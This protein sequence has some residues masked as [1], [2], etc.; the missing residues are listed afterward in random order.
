S[1]SAASFPLGS[2]RPYSR[3]RMVTRWPGC[4]PMVDEPSAAAM[5]GPSTVTRTV[6]SRDGACSNV[7]IAVATLV[8]LAGAA[9]A[10]AA[11][12]KSNSP[13]SS[14]TTATSGAVTGG[15]AMASWRCGPGRASGTAL[16]PSSSDEVIQGGGPLG[17]TSVL[18]TQ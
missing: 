16:S 6:V 18:A 1:C 14:S 13:V 12:P 2:S 15:G 17:A 9:C 11:R 8:V 5:A 7:T 10:W 4:K 3:V